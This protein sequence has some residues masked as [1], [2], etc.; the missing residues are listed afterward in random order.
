MKIIKTLLILL[1]IY[2]LLPAQTVH[3]KDTISFKIDMDNLVQGIDTS[4]IHGLKP[5]VIGRVKANDP[6]FNP[7]FMIR[8]F[9]IEWQKPF[10]LFWIDDSGMLYSNWWSLLY[11]WKLNY[12]QFKL[13]VCCY[14]GQFTICAPVK[15]NFINTQNH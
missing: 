9:S 10:N 2:I 3:L 15:V 6:D 4:S 5:V 7:E 8:D 14:D 12:Y 1:F 11:A 13:Q